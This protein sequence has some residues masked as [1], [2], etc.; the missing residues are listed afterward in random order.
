MTGST[1][2]TPIARFLSAG[3]AAVN[4][5]RADCAGITAAGL[6]LIVLWWLWLPW[7][8]VIIAG[9]IA[10]VLGGVSLFFNLR[11]GRTWHQQDVL[12][13]KLWTA[14]KRIPSGCALDDPVTGQQIAVERDRGWLILAAGDPASHDG[15]DATVSRYMLGRWAAP[16]PPPMFR[17]LAAVSDVS[18]A[19]WRW[20][21][22]WQ[23]LDMHAQARGLEVTADELADLLAQVNRAMAQA[24]APRA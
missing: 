20:R 22:H 19:R 24:A 13:R 12:L 14:A 23:F 6:L 4:N 2:R 8:A 1:E 21:Q 11:R 7:R 16:N 15:P 10:A 18:P 3:R 9:V 17:H 5:S